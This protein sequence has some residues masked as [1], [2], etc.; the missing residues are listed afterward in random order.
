MAGILEYF[1]N[2][3]IDVAKRKYYNVNKVN[4]VLEELRSQAVELVEEN[5]KQRRELYQLRSEL[6]QLKANGQQS[7]D[8]LTTM[9][10]IYRETL[11]KAHE[12]AD[13]IIREADES[14]TKASQEA[15]QKA[16]FAAKQMEEVINAIR[17]REEQNIDFLETRLAQFLKVLNVEAAEQ[18]NDEA[19]PLAED[20]LKSDDT[21]P[22][23]QDYQND[24]AEMGTDGHLKELELKI[25]KLA[26]E[27]SALESGKE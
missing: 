11:A 8:M 26:E 20:K 17:T 18:N 12:R 21:E 19:P 2:I 6:D 13:S 4:A 14:S 9:Q 7:Q 5:E 16:A 3:S 24:E 25:R 22:E 27:I 10:E 23:L 15:E 1:D